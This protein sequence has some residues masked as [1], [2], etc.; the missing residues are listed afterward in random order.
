VTMLPGLGDLRGNVRNTGASTYFSTGSALARGAISG[1]VLDLLSGA[2]ARGARVDARVTGDTTISWLTSADST[3]AFVLPHLPSQRF[4][5]RAYADKNKNLGVDPDEAWDSATVA[6]TDSGS[7]QLLIVVRDTLPPRISRAQPS[8]SVTLTVTFDRPA[9][10][11]SALTAANYVVVAAD[12]SVVPILSVKRPRSAAA[13]TPTPTLAR[14]MPAISVELTLGRP[15]VVKKQYSVR[16]TGIRGILGQTLPSEATFT[17]TAPIPPAP[18]PGGAV[19]I[20]PPKK[21]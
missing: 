15:L 21:K 4:L 2:P 8:D 11:A 3:G 14:P 9:D 6:L 13:N 5:V 19:P 1:S 17:F 16:A 7:V 18:L 10:S 12:S 20:P